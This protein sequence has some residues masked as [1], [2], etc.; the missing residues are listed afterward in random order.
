MSGVLSVLLI[1]EYRPVREVGGDRD[2]DERGT[3]AGS[4]RTSAA[5]GNWR[6]RETT[7]SGTF[8]LSARMPLG[9]S[10]R[11]T[12]IFSWAFGAADSDSEADW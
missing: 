2:E 3:K 10:G 11:R 7:S 6:S 12:T 1:K 9:A 8:S 4:S 5:H